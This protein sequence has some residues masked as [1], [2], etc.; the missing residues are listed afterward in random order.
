MKKLKFHHWLGIGLLILLSSSCTNLEY[1]HQAAAGHWQPLSQSR[2]LD[3]FFDNPTTSAKLQTRLD[4]ARQMRDF[5][6]QRLGLPDNDSY[7]SYADLGRPYVLYNV[8]AAE[9]LAL[10]PYNWCYPLVGCVSYRG[11]FDRKRAEREAAQLRQRGYDTTV[12]GVPAY[13]SLGWTNDPLLNTFINWPAGLLA[14][15]IFHEL[16][17]QQLYIDNDTAFNESF[18]TAVGH[19]G[20]ELW[21]QDHP[22]RQEAYRRLKH[23]QKGFLEL[24]QATR[25]ELAAL[26]A[27]TADDVSKRQA[28]QTILADLQHRYQRLKQ[29]QWNGFSG[30]DR[31]FAEPPNNA[32]LLTVAAYHDYV[33]AFITLYE[34]SGRNFPKFYRAVAKLGALPP[35]E[36]KHQL[37]VLAAAN[38]EPE[39][40]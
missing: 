38:P 16:A 34:Q 7:R 5:A 10:E 2:P 22:Q 24:L 28:K 15:L 18:A 14:E 36:R 12:A 26:Y 25:S 19:L 8:F 6:S 33:P 27:S 30:Y 29:E 40:T 23:Y 20:A 3:T 32:K 35:Q 9:A 21:L 17:H 39:N 11:Y 1:Y 13:S 4:L 37:G 31:W